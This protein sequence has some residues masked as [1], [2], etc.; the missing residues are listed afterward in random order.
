MRFEAPWAFLILLVIPIVVYLHRRRGRGSLR[1]SST[2]HASSVRRS[3]RQRLMGLPLLL[4]VLALVMM[5]AAL[6]RPQEGVEHVRDVNKGIAIEM[7]VDRSGSMGAEMEIDGE[8]LTRLE[9]VKRVF[10]EFVTGTGSELSG[11]FNDLI[12][13]V[14]FARYADTI[15][16]LTLAHGALTQFLENVQLVKRREEDGT[17]IGDAI[18]LAAARLRTAEETL[19]RQVEEDEKEF[20]IKSKIIILLTDGQN[21]AGKRSPEEAAALAQEWGIKIYAIGVGG[22]EGFLHKHGLFGSFLL[23]TGEGVDQETLKSIAGATGGIFRMAEDAGSLRAIY[24]EIDQ[25]ERSEIESVRYLDYRELFQ[26]FLFLA[27]GFLALEVV[28]SS[29]VFRKIP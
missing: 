26:L 22:K 17:A 27:L 18:A 5:A 23:R 4:R 21:N 10:N 15:C 16:P 6:A 11:R 8:R 13:M 14:S 12:G 3:L 28:L 19:A 2:D 24:H 7:V 1:F 20:E 29:T 25:M 9:V